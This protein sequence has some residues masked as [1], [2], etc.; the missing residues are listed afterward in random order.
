MGAFHHIRHSPCRCLRH[1]KTIGRF[2]MRFMILWMLCCA[3]LIAT[4]V[5]ASCDVPRKWQ[6]WTK[7]EGACTNGRQGESIIYGYITTLIYRNACWRQC[8]R[9]S[10]RWCWVQI[11]DG[12]RYKSIYADANSSAA[13]KVKQCQAYEWKKELRCSCE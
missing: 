2:R 10:G 3:S 8:Y 4:S 13:E 1:F 9:G 7:V 11:F 5:Q 12:S 6:K